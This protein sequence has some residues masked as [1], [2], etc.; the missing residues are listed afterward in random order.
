MIR[1]LQYLLGCPHNET[2]WPRRRNNTN[3]VRCLECG[4]EMQY[5]WERMRRGPNR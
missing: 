5:D 2:T 4:Q 3:Y 1:L